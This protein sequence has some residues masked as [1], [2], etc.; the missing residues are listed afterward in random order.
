MAETRL[1]GRGAAP[2]I[3]MGPVAVLD[4]R[5]AARTPRADQQDEAAD[6]TAS[7]HEAAAALAALIAGQS[8]DAA[9]MLAF[10][11]AMLT[12]PALTDP[13]LRAIEAGAP[14]DQAWRAAMA[15]EIALYRDGHDETFAAR[16]ADLA[17]LEARVLARL[18]GS[19]DAAILPG[20][21]LVGTD[22]TPSRFVAT[23]WAQGGGIALAEGSAASHVAMLARARGVP[24]V[25]GLGP[26]LLSLRGALLIDGG[27]GEVVGNASAATRARFS[28]RHAAQGARNAVAL[29]ASTRPAVTACGTRVTMLVNIGDLAELA[30]I[31]P[32]ICDGVG[33]TRTEFLFGAGRPLPDEAEQL[34]AYAA[35]LRWAGG[36]PV[37]IRTL[38]AGADKPI[39]GLTPPHESNPF[40][41]LRG[42]RL[43]LAHPDVFRVQLRALARAAV[44]GP[45][46]VMLPM[47]GVPAELEAARALLATEVAALRAAGIAAAMPPLGIMVEVPAAALAIDTFD[48]A[49]VS[50]GSNDLTQYVMAAARDI[51]AVAGLV[52]ARNAAV[53]RLIRMVVAAAGAKHIEASLCGDAGGDPAAIPDLL[54]AGLRVLSAAPGLIGHAKLAIGATHVLPAGVAAT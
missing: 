6:F 46:K 34:A 30:R 5:F 7:L 32:A 27:A 17:D 31:D 54:R 53:L 11:H 48:A 28:Q 19:S 15:A 44:L 33:L 26:T 9:D 8:G 47:V 4:Q 22:I 39:P 43:S 29:A 23:D 42:I 41:G 14:A 3:A 45:L 21:V 18:A 20:A 2:G 37:T 25:V 16:A 40:L 10:Q 52:D 35:V 51:G 24:M 49:F 38:D 12:D 13:V 50:I 36:R 1:S